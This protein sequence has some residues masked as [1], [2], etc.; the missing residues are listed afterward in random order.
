MAHRF[1]PILVALGLFAVAAPAQACGRQEKD[2]GYGYPA[3]AMVA[4]NSATGK[5]RIMWRLDGTL[6]AGEDGYIRL[7][8]H[9]IGDSWEGADKG[10]D[11]TA[12]W[13]ISPLQDGDKRGVRL[14]VSAKREGRTEVPLRYVSKLGAPEDMTFSIHVDPPE[15]PP[16]PPTLTV[17]DEIFTGA[18]R[19]HQTF[20]ISLNIPLPSGYRW[21]VKEAQYTPYGSDGDKWLPMEPP[22]RLGGDGLFR[23]SAQGRKARIVFIQKSDGWQLFPDTVTLLL[24]VMPTPK[25]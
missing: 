6:R 19:E 18:V 22:Q 23:A 7:M 15:P 5:S 8:P 2:M 25:C 14:R 21:D 16:P 13:W 11:D 3:R 10:G 20:Q 4:T 17:G 1:S 9:E 12:Q 24:D